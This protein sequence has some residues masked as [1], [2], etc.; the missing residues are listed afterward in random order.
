MNFKGTRVA[1]V[2]DDG[3]DNSDGDVQ[4]DGD[5]DHGGVARDG[6]SDTP[7]VSVNAMSKS[8]CHL[9]LCPHDTETLD[10]DNRA[11]TIAMMQI[12]SLASTSLSLRLP[13]RH[14]TYLNS[15]CQPSPPNP[16][17]SRMQKPTKN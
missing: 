13:C 1:G 6:D 2:D 3:N 11:K 17:H 14:E 5:A 12:I 7:R 8:C 15:F 16:A 9:A 4:D 10:L